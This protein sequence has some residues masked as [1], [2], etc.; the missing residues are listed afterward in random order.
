[1]EIYIDKKADYILALKGNQGLLHEDVSGFF[2][3][4]I[5]NNFKNIKHDFYEDFD[6]GHGRIETR[7]CWV[8]TPQK[9]SSCF[10]NLE[11][12]RNL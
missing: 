3:D 4:A 2:N 9:H 6:S 10:S 7:C 11:K 1:M 8:I 12:W 5:K